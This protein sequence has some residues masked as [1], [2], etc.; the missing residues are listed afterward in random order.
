MK[1]NK[2]LN[3]K[4]TL[5]KKTISNL[6]MSKMTFAKGGVSIPCLSRRCP[7]PVSDVGGSICETDNCSVINC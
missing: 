5:N 6:D 4:L 3:K 7:H 2:K 1:N